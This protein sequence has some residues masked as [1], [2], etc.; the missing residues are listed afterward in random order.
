MPCSRPPAGGPP[1]IE[2]REQGARLT[3][4]LTGDEPTAV[5][6]PRLE[7]ALLRLWLEA[8][9]LRGV[10]QVNDCGR[11]GGL[12]ARNVYEYSG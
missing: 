8:E 4:G 9:L 2:P 6:G 7:Q 10:N 12:S 3:D 11:T 5:T 1:L